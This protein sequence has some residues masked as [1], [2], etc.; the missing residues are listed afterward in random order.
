MLRRV[1]RPLFAYFALA[2]VLLWAACAR[3]AWAEPYLGIYAGAAFTESKDL[4]T[5][6]ELNGVP[7][8]N[9][10]AHDL[11]FDTSPVFGAKAGYFFDVDLLGGNAGL[12]VDVYHFEPDAPRQFV[13]FKGLLAGV[14]AD[15]RTELQSADIQVTAVTLNAIYRFRLGADAEHP[16]GR[17]QP[18]VGVGGGAFIAKLATKTSPFDVNSKIDDTQTKAG[19]Q[20]L[21]GARWFITNNIA[22][23]AEYKF[24]QT[25]TFAF[26]FKQAGTISGFPF[27]ET[28]RD[29]A[30][31]TSHL[32]YGGLGL[33]W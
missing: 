14:P 9:G 2:T 13:R 15:T 19:F 25:D 12:E 31:I 22:L 5:E 29:R 20:A 3:P 17:F 7:F 11:K 1:P 4:R 10:R 8:V 21:A 33:H 28:A 23:F 30:D 16:L 32:L 18:Y 26:R 6:L 24:V 27:T